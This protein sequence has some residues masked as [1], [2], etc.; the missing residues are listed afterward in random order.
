MAPRWTRPARAALV[1][2]AL[3]A[4]AAGFAAPASASD[5]LVHLRDTVHLTTTLAK[6][7]Q[8]VVF[9]AGR[10]TGTVDGFTGAT[11]A[12]LSLPPAT[13]T[14]SVVGIGLADATI[15]VIEQ[16]KITGTLTFGTASDSLRATATVM[17][18]IDSLRP[19]GTTV[20]LV[21]SSCETATPVTLGLD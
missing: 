19:V 7:H 3:A 9:P 2:T 21:G 8:T 4:A 10:L 11:Q 13:T 14:V 17:V 6:L 15:S 12:T 20:N 18:K 1:G 16:R 5:P